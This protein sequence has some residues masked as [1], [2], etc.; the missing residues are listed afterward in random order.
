MICNVI[1]YLLGYSVSTNNY[2]VIIYQECDN[3]IVY[4]VSEENKFKYVQLIKYIEE[5]DLYIIQ[6]K[7]NK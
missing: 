6:N 2:E 4:E 5:E 1:A 7:E 3:K